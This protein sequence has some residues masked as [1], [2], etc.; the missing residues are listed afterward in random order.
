MALHGY[1]SSILMCAAVLS[2]LLQLLRHLSIPKC[3]LHRTILSGS[4]MTKAF[5]M[6]PERHPCNKKSRE[7][8]TARDI[9]CIIAA[10]VFRSYTIFTSSILVELFY[11]YIFWFCSILEVDFVLVIFF[12]SNISDKIITEIQFAAKNFPDNQP[13]A[14]EGLPQILQF[15]LSFLFSF[16]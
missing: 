14:H 6:V 10:R 12:S 16:C 5:F 4:T 11:L 1:L 2:L 7:K 15:T 13:L 9:H 8:T 3:V